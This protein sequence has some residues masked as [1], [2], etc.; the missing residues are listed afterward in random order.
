[1]KKLF[2]VLLAFLSLLFVCNA[3]VFAEEST[4]S[5]RTIRIGVVE[6]PGLQDEF[7]YQMLLNQMRGYLSEI[8]KHKRWHY[9]YESGSYQDCVARLR[10]GELD[11]VGPVE[12]GVTTAG[13]VF[14]GGVP[15]WTLLHFYRLEEASQTPLLSQAAER[16]TIGMIADEMNQSAL[17]FFMAKNDWHAN[18]RPF[19]DAPSMR[20][21]LE[22]G[23]IDAVCDNGSHI[24][25]GMRIEQSFSIVPARLMTTPDKQALC[26]EMTDVVL[27]IETL[28]PGF[29]TS[30]KGKYVDRALQSIIRPTRAAKRFVEEAGELRV[31][32]LPDFAPFFELREDGTASGFYV[33]VLQLLSEGSGLKFSFLRAES[34]PQLW[35]MLTLGEADLAFVSYAGETAA[36]DVYYTGDVREEEFSV[37]RRKDGKVQ[38]SARHTAVIPAGFPGA[39]AYFSQKHHQR[40][41]VAESVEKCLDSVEA[42]IYE[43]AYI[44]SLCLRQEDMLFYRTSLEEADHEPVTLPVALALSPKQPSL[45]QSILNRAILHM[46]A[47]EVERLAMKNSRPT[48][49][50]AYLLEQY[51]LR[52]ALFVGFVIAGLAGLF[53]VLSRNRL[54]KRQNEILQQKNK[55]LE[56]ALKRVEDLRI[57]RDSYKLESET[58]GLT[59][60]Y[61]KM[62]FESAVRKKLEAMPQSMT[63]AFYIIDMD[64]FKEANDTYGHRCGD[65]ILK[66]FAAVLKEVFRQSDCLGRFG[67]DEFVAFIEG[68]LTRE[69]AARKAEQVVEAARAIEVEDTD[70]HVTVSIGAAMYPEDGSNYDFLFSAAD[71]ALYHVKTAGRDG[72]SVVSPGVFR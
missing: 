27:T 12:P 1:M 22:N 54:Q 42:G 46:D 8:S 25:P 43:E 59:E 69:S 29:G 65:I 34:E 13:M 24:G 49:S 7:A 66:K 51:P 9:V 57:S 40:V 3:H 10:R 55:D 50:V 64:H 30:L 31:A 38:S 44:P 32:F 19:F 62:G 2:F 68:D 6:P 21:A 17:S 5:G 70:I 16:V 33:D 14:V 18:I 72:Y 20:A 39:E 48:L 67:G 47:N 23:E 58:D 63:G 11:F 15:N 45:L 41:R 4:G 26:A 52:T 28:N 53:F 60:L 71:R 61:N 36:M 37:I 35:K 56:L